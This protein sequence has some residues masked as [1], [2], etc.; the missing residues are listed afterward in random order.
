MRMANEE[1]TPQTMPFTVRPMAAEDIAQSA[2][3]ERD[4][5]PTLFPPT[6]FRR[7]LSNKRA[8]YLVAQR[9][10]GNGV[11]PPP[12]TPPSRQDPLIGR[13]V[14]QIWRRRG[15]SWAPGQNFITGFV[16]I[17]YMVDEAHIVAIGVRSAYRGLGVGELMLIAS[18]EQA[19]EMDARVVTLEVRVSNLVAQNLYKK[20]GFTERGVRKGY[21]TDNREDAFIMTTDPVR[22]DPFGE[23]FTRL[24]GEHRHRWGEAN[25]K[26]F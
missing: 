4:A 1:P 5:F 26:L 3:V 24:V 16:G 23:R 12:H 25:R 21:Y 2:E 11:A 15:S 7:E 8:R 10:D 13:L 14:R 18:I 22:S 17:W 19:L 6:S 20:F 9:L